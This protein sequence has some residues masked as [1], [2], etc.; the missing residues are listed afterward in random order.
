MGAMK[1]WITYMMQ[2]GNL[3]VQQA[4]LVESRMT[5]VRLQKNAYFSEPGK[6]PRQV[7]F[8]LDGVIRSC[9]VNSQGE[10]IT[11]CFVS[12]QSLIVDYDHFEAG[13]AASEYLQAITDCRLI[14][15]AKNDWEELSQTVAGWDNLRNKMIQKC[16]FWKTRKGPVISQ[17]ATTRYLEFIENHPTL[18]NRIPL[19][20][21]ASYL[22]VTQQSL[23]RIRKNIR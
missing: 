14:V 17:D 2:F 23:S 19:A 6:I 15:M 22:G 16:L 1:E 10:E 5:E 8:I 4:A 12:A 18:T 11:R 13:T 7:G 20:Y 9:Y 21:I 3:T